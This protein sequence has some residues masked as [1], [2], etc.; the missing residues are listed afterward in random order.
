[1]V[2]SSMLS[3]DWFFRSI[4]LHSAISLLPTGGPLEDPWDIAWHW[5]LDGALRWGMILS[6]KPL[7]FPSAV[8]EGVFSEYPSSSSPPRMLE[9]EETRTEGKVAMVCW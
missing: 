9:E 2:R 8:K 5:G 1:M 3:H 7:L 4:I 6:R